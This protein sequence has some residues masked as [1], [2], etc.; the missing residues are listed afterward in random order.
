M[1]CRPT[2]EKRV[3]RACGRWRDAG[4][5]EVELR[6][7]AQHLGLDPLNL[8]IGDVLAALERADRL[9]QPPSNPQIPGGSE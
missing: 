2:A 3:H 5:F 1:T 4:A 8:G 9:S 7:I 6:L